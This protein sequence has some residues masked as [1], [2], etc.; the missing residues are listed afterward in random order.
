MENLIGFFCGFFAG[1]V[2]WNYILLIF[3]FNLRVF[4]VSWNENMI[5]YSWQVGFWFCNVTGS[6]PRENS[7]LLPHFFFKFYTEFLHFFLA[8]LYFFT[9]PHS[10][11][12]SK[13]PAKTYSI[14]QSRRIWFNKQI[15]TR[16]TISKEKQIIIQFES[17][18]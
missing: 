5:K 17:V 16:F 7:F 8:F 9:Y 3:L 1:W 18:I 14:T 6:I 4:L 11:L 13:I 10:K 2:I 12:I 15:Y